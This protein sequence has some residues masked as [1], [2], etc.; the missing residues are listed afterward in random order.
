MNQATGT[1]TDLDVEKLN[2]TL[3]ILDDEFSEVC[4]YDDCKEPRTHLLACPRCPAVENICESH[5][6]MAKTAPPRQRVVFNRSCFHNVPMISCGKI[7]VK[8]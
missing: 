3:I 5:A 4:E 1:Q 7:R 2:E 8:N 6:T